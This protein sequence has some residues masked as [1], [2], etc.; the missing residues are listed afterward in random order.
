MKELS[1]IG[2]VNMKEIEKHIE[3]WILKMLELGQ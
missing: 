3:E 1:D 2:S